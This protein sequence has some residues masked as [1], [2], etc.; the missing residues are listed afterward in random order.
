MVVASPVYNVTGPRPDRPDGKYGIARNSQTV[1]RRATCLMSP[2]SLA[3]AERDAG[4]RLA[5]R[6]DEIFGYFGFCRKP[7]FAT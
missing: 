4:L 7:S 2:E 1:G 5:R 6:S 3:R